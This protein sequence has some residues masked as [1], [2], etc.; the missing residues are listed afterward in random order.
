[1]QL[2]AL[3]LALAYA[4]FAAAQ[5]NPID[6]P[7]VNET[8]IGPQ[9][10]P[11]GP[12]VFKFQYVKERG[13]YYYFLSMEELRERDHFEEARC[14]NAYSMEVEMIE[15]YPAGFDK[16]DLACRM[17]ECKDCKQNGHYSTIEYKKDADCYQDL[18]NCAP[19][20]DPKFIWA[21]NVASM[22]CWKPSRG[23]PPTGD[24][25]VTVL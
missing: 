10:R 7:G 23:F 4:L 12:V 22:R 6:I 17:Y 20:E 9:G 1:M 18:N 21:K 19:R 16:D 11:V 2:T 14:Y 5:D 25:G 8:D 24:M 13:K 15:F 3:L